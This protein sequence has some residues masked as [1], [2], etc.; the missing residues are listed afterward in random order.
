MTEGW[1]IWEANTGGWITLDTGERIFVRYG[2]ELLCET[3]EDGAVT[4]LAYEPR[5]VN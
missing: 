4:W 3:D 5:T 1:L 2:D